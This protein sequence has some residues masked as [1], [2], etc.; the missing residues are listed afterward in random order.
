MVDLIRIDDRL[1]HGQVMAAWA[2]ALRTTRILVLDDAAAADLF[3]RQVMQAAMPAH[4]RLE[5]EPIRQ[6][7]ARLAEA[8]RDGSRTLALLRDVEAA[9]R[10][11]A[12]HP[13]RAL[14]VGGAGMAQGRQLVWRSIALSPDELAALRGLRRDGVDVYLQMIPSDPRKPIED[15][16]S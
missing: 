13:L 8:E 3:S 9:A 12:L 1:V 4:I 11:H 14:N 16:D 7:A 15:L 10:L 5:V 2:R 6:S